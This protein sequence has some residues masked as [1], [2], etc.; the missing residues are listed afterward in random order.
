[1]TAQT[2]KPRNKLARTYAAQMQAVMVQHVNVKCGGK[3]I[4]TAP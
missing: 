1:M 2:N 3:A 4:V